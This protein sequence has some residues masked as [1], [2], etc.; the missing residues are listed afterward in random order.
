MCM[1]ESLEIKE[2]RYVYLGLG[3]I[4]FIFLSVFVWGVF[5][6]IDTSVIAPGKVMVKSYRKPVQYDSL[7]R[8][9][10]I[11]V[12]EGQFVKKGD[13]LLELEEIKK[14]ADLA[15]LKK[16][17]YYLLA[18]RD[19][20]ISELKGREK[21]E[22]SEEFLSLPDERL[23]EEN[24][25][26]QEVVFRKRRKKLLSDLSVMRSRLKN[27]E[28]QER[29]TEELIRE[30]E[31]LLRKYEALMRKYAPLVAKGLVSSYEVERLEISAQNVRVELEELKVRLGDIKNRIT[32]TRRQIKALLENYRKEVAEQLDRV[33]A[34]L[35]EV[36]DRFYYSKKEVKKT[37]LKAPAD[38]QVIGLKVTSPGEVVKP[39]D[40]LMYIVPREREFL[41]KVRISPRDRDKVREGMLVD[42]RFPSFLGIG[43]NFIEGKVV[44]VSSDTLKDPRRGYE[45]YEG[46]VVL[47]ERGKKQLKEYGFDLVSGMPAVAF[48]RVEKVSPLEYV[49]QPVIIILKSAFK[50]N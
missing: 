5:A 43:A 24:A 9:N 4:L 8:V 29:G 49:L 26:A 3:V 46:H 47:T 11:F 38:G 21:V 7:A 13:T 15:V 23:R 42:L 40:T 2:K 25:R 18:L 35:E 22:F 48:I 1:V 32:E 12:K 19:R 27:L 36:K 14:E 44:Y 16:R 37:L 41:I 45:Y 31:K 33:N 28:E 50:S 6:R 20:L 30:K 39:G 17:L 34:Q 10:R